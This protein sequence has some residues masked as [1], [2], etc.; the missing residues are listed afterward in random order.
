MRAPW[1]D[2]WMDA[3]T[4]AA[5]VLALLGVLSGGPVSYVLL[6]VATGLTMLIVR[7]EEVADGAAVT[8]EA[9]SPTDAWRGGTGELV[10]QR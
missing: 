9:D 1:T 7:Q 8:A 2:G 3:T 4:A 6:T 5:A 10:E